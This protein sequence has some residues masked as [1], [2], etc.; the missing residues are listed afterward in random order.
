MNN[1]YCK[2]SEDGITEFFKILSFLSVAQFNPYS[3]RAVCVD[4][5]GNITTPSIEQIIV[6]KSTEIPDNDF[7]LL[8]DY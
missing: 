5:D 8:K 2:I 6:I 1:I 4:G 3:A 7:E